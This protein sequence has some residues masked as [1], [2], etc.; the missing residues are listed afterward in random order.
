MKFYPHVKKKIKFLIYFFLSRN[1]YLINSPLQYV[2]LVEFLNHKDQLF[3]K[4][5][6][7]VGYT[8]LNAKNQIKNLNSNI[9]FINLNLFYLDEIFSVK[10]FHYIFGIQKI[11]KRKYLSV[12]CGDFKYYLFKEFC[13]KSSVVD[14]IDDGYSSISFINN[15]NNKMLNYRLFTVFDIGKSGFKIKKN[16]H[17]YL[18]NKIGIKKKVDNSLIFLLG[19]GIFQH[20]KRVNEFEPLLK[21]FCEKNIDKKIIYFPH[22]SENID[23]IKNIGI[24]NL[25]L[26]KT[27]EPIETFVLRHNVLPHFIAGFYSAALYNLRK[28]LADYDTKIVNINFALSEFYFEKHEEDMINDFLPYLKSGEIKD[29]Y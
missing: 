27:N 16:N 1:F 7:L 26:Q 3:K 8:S 13:K 28:L 6:I 14:L 12:L 2:N 22:R 23:F 18:K 24:K 20:E 17:Y 5:N 19:T 4:K 11:L 10:I 25:E 29:F 21:N 9:Y 15:D